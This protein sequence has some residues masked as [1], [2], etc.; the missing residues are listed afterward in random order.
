MATRV[1]RRKRRLRRPRRIWMP[2]YSSSEA[3]QMLSIAPITLRKLSTA[4][5]A[6]LSPTATGTVMV[7]ETWDR[8]YND[9]DLDTVRYIITLL[10]QKRNYAWVRE[11]LTIEFGAGD[12]AHDTDESEPGQPDQADSQ[13]LESDPSVA[14]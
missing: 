1:K 2:A 14:D 3:A 4:F 5:A 12:L 9:D 11:R 8:F 7:D 10:K 6:W 13:V